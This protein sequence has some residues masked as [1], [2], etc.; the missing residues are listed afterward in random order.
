MTTAAV[1]EQIKRER[2]GQAA[3]AQ[4]FADWLSARGIA[5]LGPAIKNTLSA[6]VLLLARQGAHEQP[7]RDEL[8][9]LAQVMTAAGRAELARKPSHPPPTRS[10]PPALACAMTFSHPLWR[11]PPLE[12]ALPDYLRRLCQK[13][14][15]AIRVNT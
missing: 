15:A 2:E 3:V 5:N 7:I 10:I 1:A 13:L 12:K 9:R 8:F 11:P 14:S 4:A 6:S